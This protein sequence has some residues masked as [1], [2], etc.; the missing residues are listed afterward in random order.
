MK[1]NAWIILLFALASNSFSQKIQS[2][3]AYFGYE[4]GTYFTRHHQVVDYFKQLEKNAPS[5]IKVEKYGATNEK[6]DLI[7]AYISTPENLKNLEQ[8]KQNHSNLSNESVAFVWLS[9]NVH[10]N[11]SAGTEAAMQTAFELITQRQDWLKSTVVILDPCINPDGR[12]RYVNWYN[13]QYNKTNNTDRVSNE[14]N[15][16]WPSGRPNQCCLP[17]RTW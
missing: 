1:F 4:L 3:S 10:G 7:V 8:L 13:Q 2:P 15:E 17:C 11:E 5:S 14:H 16:P 9:Y 6:R 12:D